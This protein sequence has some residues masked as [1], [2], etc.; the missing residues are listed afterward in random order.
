MATGANFREPMSTPLSSLRDLPAG[1]K[2]VDGLTKL[3]ASSPIEDVRVLQ[4]QVDVV[5]QSEKVD[6]GLGAR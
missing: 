3:S 5:A 6:A 4:Q 1:K 2:W